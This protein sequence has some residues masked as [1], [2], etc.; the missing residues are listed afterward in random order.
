MNEVTTLDISKPKF[1]IRNY[2]VV[3]ITFAISRL[4][5]ALMMFISGRNS[6]SDIL[7]L[8]DAEHYINI[9]KYGYYSNSI[10]AFFPFFPLIIRLTG[11]VGAIIINNLC[12]LGSILVLD[13]L[14]LV[15]SKRT[16]VSTIILMTFALSP[17]GFFS[18]LLYT[19]SIF[20]FFTI[21]CFYLFKL[22][23]HFF[24][25]GILLGLCVCTRNTGSMLFAAIFIAL[26]ILWYRKEIKFTDILKQYIPATILSISYPV[27]LQYKFGNWKLFVDTQ[28]DIWLKTNSNIIKTA[29][30]SLKIVFTDNVPGDGEVDTIALF[31][32]NEALS[33]IILVLCITLIVIEIIHFKRKPS[34]DSFA[35][36]LF[37]FLCIFC[38]NLSI[39]NPEIDCPT[40][41]YFRYYYGTFPIFYLLKNLKQ[42]AL[43]F[44]FIG[45]LVI[46]M[47]TSLVF[48]LG[49]FFY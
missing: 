33:L 26:C 6:Y 5:F 40:I 30:I 18:M 46:S 32:L 8:F 22:R 10:T 12:F 7:E 34:I 4:F 3:L 20:V 45:T 1:D 49:V 38:I 35:C 42:K 29:L 31:K 21:L 37:F 17:I 43:L 27:F 19:E 13:K 25:S 24:L 39:R 36:L 16:Q 9:A 28:A 44:V 47:V 41:S 14:L 48:S 23:K 15:D 2:S 11:R